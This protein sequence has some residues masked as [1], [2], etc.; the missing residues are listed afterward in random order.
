MRIAFIG[1]SDFSDA[2]LRAVLESGGEVVSITTVA[3]QMLRHHT[4]Y[5][6]LEPLAQAHEIPFARVR[7]I[8]DADA[9]GFL[10]ESAPDVLFVF[11]WSQLLSRELLT[12]APEGALGTHPQVLPYFR[13]RHAM[14]WTIAQGHDHGGVSF[15]W[16]DEGVDTGD[17][18]WVGEF[19]IAETDDAADAYARLKETAVRGIH[20][21]MPR[22]LMGERPRTSQDH[23]LATYWRKRTDDDRLIRWGGTTRES[24]DR[25]RA[26][27]R[28]YIGAIARK[29]GREIVIWRA[30][31]SADTNDQ[32]PVGRVLARRGDGI[33][34]RTADGRL[35]IVELQPDELVEG[36]QLELFPPSLPPEATT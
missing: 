3:P 12:L 26:L 14:Q 11:G 10:R 19:P 25:V 7:N 4:D 18:L 34:V 20:E 22:L 27:A 8:N 21:F 35:T 24:Y 15:F 13:G 23:S 1:L 9:L 6:D 36:D 31:I 32:A 30:R 2:C 16:L 28:P 29:D 17:V 5:V 33:D